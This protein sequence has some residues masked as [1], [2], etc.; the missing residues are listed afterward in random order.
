MEHK[1]KLNAGT[2]LVFILT[3]RV[4][5]I[6]NTEMGVVGILPLIADTFQV[7]VTEVSYRVISLMLLI[8]GLANI[9]GNIL[10]GK[11]LSVNAVRSMV[12]IPFGLLLAYICVFI[13]GE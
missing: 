9:V 8:Y 13:F 10:A 7:T 3:V 12:I 5:G 6:I 4:F 2:L 11:L 1:R